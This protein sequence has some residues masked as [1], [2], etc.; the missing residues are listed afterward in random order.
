MCT[1]TPTASR[2]CPAG[3]TYTHTFFHSSKV[4]TSRPNS[5]TWIVTSPQAVK[6]EGAMPRAIQRKELSENWD[7]LTGLRNSR[8]KHRLASKRLLRKC[9]DNQVDLTVRLMAAV[10]F[11][12]TDVGDGVKSEFASLSPILRNRLRRTFPSWAGAKR[13]LSGSAD[14]KRNAVVDNSLAAGIC[15]SVFL[16]SP[17]GEELA[18]GD[19]ES[20]G[21]VPGGVPGVSAQEE[22]KE[23]QGP[24]AAPDA[25]ASDEDP[26]QLH[27][28]GA[29]ED[30]A[31]L[32]GAGGPIPAQAS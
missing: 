16:Q 25:S 1:S 28:S 3:T 24:D 17:E 5:S 32:D 15:A 10:V 19:N 9:D 21:K 8:K 4:E 29:Q 6:G 18:G 2:P 23:R 26:E 20:G 13:V 30:R 7:F 11:L 31:H 22:E 27:H 14:A 12:K